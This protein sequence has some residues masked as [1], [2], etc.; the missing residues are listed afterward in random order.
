MYL[1]KKYIAM[2]INMLLTTHSSSGLIW[3]WIFLIRPGKPWP[4]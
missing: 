3:D 2:P 1:S 4:G